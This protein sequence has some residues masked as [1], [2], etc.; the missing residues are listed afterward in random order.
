MRKRSVFQHLSA[1]SPDSCADSL[2]DTTSNPTRVSMVEVGGSAAMEQSGLSFCSASIA[3]P[4][5]TFSDVHAWHTSEITILYQIPYKSCIYHLS[6]LTVISIFTSSLHTTT[7]HYT[8]PSQKL[9]PWTRVAQK[10]TP[11]F[12]HVPSRQN[13]A[14]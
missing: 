5:K 4:C 11:I 10:S 12:E 9:R 14:N 1:L 13:N 8:V 2:M 6:L 7:V 3:Y